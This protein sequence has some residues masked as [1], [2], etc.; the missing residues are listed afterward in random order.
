MTYKITR[1]S[2]IAAAAAAKKCVGKIGFLFG[3]EPTPPRWNSDK[4]IEIPAPLVT[5]LYSASVLHSKD[6]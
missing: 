5:L 3:F 2:V 6:H 1:V 4:R